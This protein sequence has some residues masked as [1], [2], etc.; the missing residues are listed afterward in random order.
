M[1][2][3]FTVF[4]VFFTVVFVSHDIHDI[5]PRTKVRKKNICSNDKNIVE[6]QNPAI[7]ENLISHNVKSFSI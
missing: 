6:A 2:D 3:N 4:M 7:L 1:R 5:Y